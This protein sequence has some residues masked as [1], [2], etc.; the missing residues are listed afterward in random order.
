LRSLV[1][2]GAGFIGSNLVDALVERGDSVLVLDDLSSGRR[3]NLDDALG[4]GA[5]LA[6]GS[7]T[8]AE[9][10]QSSVTAFRPES[11]F[12][13]AA[14]V[15]VRKA[16]ADPVFD[17]TVNLLGTINLLEAVKEAGGAPLVFTSTGGAIYG[18]GEGR[19]LPFTEAAAA[20]PEAPYGASKLGCE[21]YLGLYRRLY[22]LPALALRLGNVYGPRQDPAGE[23]GVVAIFCGRLREGR[24]LEVFGDGMQTRDYVFVGDVVRALVASGAA[25]SERGVELNGPYNIGTGVETTV[26]ELSELLGRAAGV[27]ATVHHQPERPGEVSRAVIDAAAAARDLSWRPM[28][29][30]AGGLATTYEW[31]AESA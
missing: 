25:L 13:L 28:I 12:H 1:S 18:E 15:D 4:R 23:A 10:V 31:L 21:V 9:F 30:L 14:Q 3:E 7:M 11:V 2:G 22:R 8:D 29:D 24:A 17:A 26:V 5:R 16:V 6:E 19:D 20:E 27:E